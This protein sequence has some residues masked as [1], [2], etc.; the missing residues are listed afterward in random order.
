[1]HFPKTIYVYVMTVG[2]IRM[3]RNDEGQDIL[4][5]LAP[6]HQCWILLN[7]SKDFSP[8]TAM[9]ISV[10]FPMQP[11]DSGSKGTQMYSN[12]PGHLTKMATITI[13]CKK[14]FKSFLTQL[15]GQSHWNLLC[16]MRWLD[17]FEFVDLDLFYGNVKVGPLRLLNGKKV[18]QTVI[19]E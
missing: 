13:Y 17:T 9:L 18:K 2:T 4:M 6:G 8:E 1:M 7:I 19:G 10:K 15:L 5:T 12:R 14:N 3:S 11:P 16:S